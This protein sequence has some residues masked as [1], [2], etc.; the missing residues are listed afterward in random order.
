[1]SYYYRYYVGYELNGKI[2]PFGIYNSNGVL[3]PVINRSRNFASDLHELFLS[4]KDDS[5]TDE[6]RKNFERE[7]W[8]GDKVTK[9]K[10]LPICELPS[11]DYIKRGYFLIK[12][13]EEYESNGFDSFDLF[14]DRLDPQTYI[15]KFKSELIFGA[16]EPEKDSEGNEFETHSISEYSYYCYPD[17]SSKEYEA[18]VIKT[19]ANLLNEYNEIPE[20]AKLVALEDEG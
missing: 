17:Y 10:Y 15:A 8:R 14:Y 12:D 9:V 20:G 2:Y 16:P 5:I 4:V 13:I 3:K 1:M 6:L 7:D 18:S 19:I 11:G